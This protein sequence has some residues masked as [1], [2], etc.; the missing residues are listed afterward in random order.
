MLDGVGFLLPEIADYEI[1]RNLILENL[2]TAIGILDGFKH[3]MV[4]LPLTTEAMQKAAELWADVRSK[5]LPTAPEEALD[6]DVIV[7]AQA[8]VASAGTEEI[9][10]A[11]INVGHLAR[12][13]TTTVTAREWSDIIPTSLPN[14]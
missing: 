6:G 13:N 10:I 14:P 7:A 3:R 4:Y 11:T 8:I 9:V 2:T 5:G 1:R 12:F